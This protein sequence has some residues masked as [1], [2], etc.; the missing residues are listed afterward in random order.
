MKKIWYTHNEKPLRFWIQ[1]TVISAVLW[2]LSGLISFLTLPESVMF[3]LKLL[4]GLCPC[5]LLLFAVLALME[6]KWHTPPL[7]EK[8]Q[9]IETMILILFG[10]LAIL[11]EIVFQ[12]SNDISYA[13]PI[14][15]CALAGVAIIRIAAPAIAKRQLRKKSGLESKLQSWDIVKVI[16]LG[17]FIA[18]VFANFFKSASGILINL[19]K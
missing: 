6:H 14:T 13:L 8:A 7:D 16:F 11:A 1:L 15:V 3:V 5:A 19:G 4:V 18:V 2:L 10:L 12:Y 9:I 17:T